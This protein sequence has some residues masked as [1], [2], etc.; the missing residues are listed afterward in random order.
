[1]GYFLR[2]W[3]ASEVCRAN[4][5]R[6]GVVYRDPDGVILFAIISSVSRGDVGV[7]WVSRFSEGDRGLRRHSSQEHLSLDAALE[8]LTAE[9]ERSRTDHG[10]V[11]EQEWPEDHES[12]VLVPPELRGWMT[13]S[14]RPPNLIN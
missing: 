9:V 6:K 11:V 4:W 5:R 2:E 3:V 14:P 12:P 8:A 7:W 10:E 1:M 13:T